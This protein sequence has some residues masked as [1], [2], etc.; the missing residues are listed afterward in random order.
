MLCFGLHHYK[1]NPPTTPATNLPYFI[2][3]GCLLWA[4]E[5]PIQPETTCVKAKNNTL[6]TAFDVVHAII[7]VQNKVID[8]AISHSH[9]G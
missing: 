9:I 1:L 7:I 2:N 6:N 5:W 3:K 4:I 8:N